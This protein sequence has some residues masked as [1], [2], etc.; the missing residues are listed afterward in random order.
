[1]PP[2]RKSTPRSSAHAALGQA[3][4]LL[5]AEDARMTQETVAAEGGLTTKQVGALVRGQSNPTYTTLM[6]VCQG[7]HV[8][9]DQLLALARDLQDKKLRSLI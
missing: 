9:P 2:Q 3:I 6:K 7:L 1:M 5:I 8:F 4:E